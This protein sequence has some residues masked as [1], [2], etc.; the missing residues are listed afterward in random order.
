VGD[1]MATAVD[2]ITGSL[3]NSS[4]VRFNRAIL[5]PPKLPQ[6]LPLLAV[7]PSGL[8]PLKSRLPWRASKA[9]VVFR[10]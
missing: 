6:A 4:S 2:T 3:F 9:W 10:G 8:L 7:Q 5:N 1:F